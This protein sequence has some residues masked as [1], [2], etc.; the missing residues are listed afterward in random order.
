VLYECLAGRRAFDGEG[1][2][3]R[4]AATL[5]T[6]PDWGALPAET[7]DSLRG[8]LAGLL[9][10]DRERRPD[11]MT[12]VRR[13]LEEEMTRR[14][15]SR[16]GGEEPASPVHDLPR[17]L[18]SFVGRRADLE[19]LGQRMRAHRLVTLTGAGGSGKSR[20]AIEAARTHA[21]DLA[22]E[23]WFVELAALGDP[24]LIPQAVARVLG[25]KETAGRGY[26]DVLSAFVRSRRVLLVLDNCEHVRDGTASLARALFDVS[27]GLRILASSRVALGVEGEAVYPVPPL[28]LPR[29]GLDLPALST[30]DSVRLFLDRARLVRPGF[31]LTEADAAHVIEI[32]RRLD[33][34]PLAL[35]LAAA[36]MRMLTAGEIARRLDQRFDLLTGTGET[37]LPHHR[38]LRA[39]IEWSH[40][41]L[42]PPE[43]VLFRRLAVFAGGWTL[44]AAESVVADDELPEWEVLDRLAG[45]VEKS[46]VEIDAE[47]ERRS[48][49]PRF[50]MLETV[51]A[52]AGERLEAA[53][54][55][56]GLGR[57]HRGHYTA[58][59]ENALPELRG[60]GQSV[61]LTRLSE[62]DENLRRAVESALNVGD[63]ET[64]LAL[65]GALGRYWDYRGRW[66]DGRNLLGRALALP[67]EGPATQN[68]ARA[69]NWIGNLSQYFG[70]YEA[71]E[72]YHRESM[73]ISRR[74]GDAWY[75]ASS[76]NNLGT[77]ASLR[78][79]FASAREHHE[80]S[81]ALRRGVGDR[82]AEALSVYQLGAVSM[83]EADYPGARRRFEESLALWKE[84]GDEHCAGIV[85]ASLGWVHLAAGDREAAARV[86][87]ESR[88]IHR[89]S[90]D[91]WAV[92]SG[93]AGFARL[94]LARG[95]LSG[96][97]VP[98]G[99]CLR[100]RMEVGDRPAVAQ[101][102]EIIAQWCVA[103]GDLES[104]ARLLGAADAVREGLGAPRSPLEESPLE[105]SRNRLRN[106]LD[107]AAQEAALEAG[108]RLS[109]EEAAAL[110]EAALA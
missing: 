37:R 11:S 12:E 49:Q 61:W 21:A 64:A 81:L 44:D 79:E 80:R 62:D 56:P 94:A 7:P 57:R 75:E 108:R 105:E 19:A 53:G 65:T 55:E 99:E 25:L 46:V 110:A 33:G 8:L 40:D 70:D 90:E 71:S 41:Q 48:G 16:F 52:F 34:I 106:G 107:P 63:A 74:N 72:G 15:L 60:R 89:G 58:L 88:E 85:L 51:R 38:T 92:S 73:E 36:R 23:T 27:P 59:A 69:L 9:E 66:T 6:D 5:E 83:R 101:C 4:I 67:T 45:L 13:I 78:G 86:L 82:W 87:E 32:C 102:L 103:G 84:V 17:P 35:E 97:R 3:E 42:T 68:R 100:L 28:D 2:A 10:K 39:L 93:Q 20:L 104:G 29:S 96:A 98:L 22:D 54:E 109:L 95:D 47:A 50:R 30:V 43:R 77:L 24:D 91:L 1:A 31:R 76:L 14:R 26:G 18:S